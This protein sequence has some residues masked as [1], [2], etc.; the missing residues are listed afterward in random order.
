MGKNNK[1]TNL[2]G[3]KAVKFAAFSPFVYLA[4]VTDIHDGDTVTMDIDL[5]FDVTMKDQKIRLYGINAPELKVKTAGVLAD[6]PAGIAA[7]ENLKRLIGQLPA[8]VIIE[9]YR[10]QREK[11]GRYLAT[12]WSDYQHPS[13]GTD[14]N[15]AQLD[16][17]NAKPMKY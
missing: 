2:A 11:Y 13:G 5:G 4:T 14:C 9:T 12:V 15:I 8:K 7:L 6:N 10:D 16:S 17:G 3:E 1:G